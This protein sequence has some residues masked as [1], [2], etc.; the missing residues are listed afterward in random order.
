MLTSLFSLQVELENVNTQFEEADAKVSSLSKHVGILESNLHDTKELLSEETR[1]KLSLQSRLRQAEEQA[2]SLRDQLE[3]EEDAK[4][5][6]ETKISSMQLQ[7]AVQQ[8]N[9]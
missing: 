9:E 5:S 4:K 1:Q 6:L 8:H 2:E 3:E 7:V